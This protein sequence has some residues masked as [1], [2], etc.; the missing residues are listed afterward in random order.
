MVRRRLERRTM[1]EQ[2]QS[3]IRI[4]EALVGE[5]DDAVL[6]ILMA[7]QFAERRAST[8]ENFD[9]SYKNW[10][11]SRSSLTRK[12]RTHF[13]N[14]DVVA[15][16]ERFSE[17]ITEFYALTGTW[18]PN[19]RPGR[20][21]RLKAYFGQD[22]TDWE[23]LASAE[24]RQADFVDWFSSWWKLREA[25]LTRKNAV[26]QDLLSAPVSGAD[27]TSSLDDRR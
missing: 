3:E 10:E 25:A 22:A 6:R 1:N 14:A 5:I 8:Q 11:L 18:N 17:A 20:I 15:E 23:K 13:R 21:E 26:T 2:S 12:L 19:Y 27:T 24:Q 4:R 7:I 16:F 9:N